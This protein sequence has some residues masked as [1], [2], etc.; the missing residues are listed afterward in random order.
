MR[1]PA[2]LRGR[3]IATACLAVCLAIA[4]AGAAVW[5]LLDRLV[6]GQVDAQLDAQI[7]TVAAALERSPRGEWRLVRPVEGPPFDRRGRGWYWEVRSGDDTPLRSASLGDG[8]VDVEDG[9]E[10]GPRDRPRPAES[11]GPRGEAL[12]ARLRRVGPG[13]PVVVATAPVEAIHG[14]LR[15]ALATVSL[16]LLAVAAA[17]VA[18]ILVQVGLGLRPLRRLEGALADVRAGRRDRVPAD[19]PT[20]LRALAGEL[21]ALLRENAETLAR[22][23]MH[24][25]NLA[26]GLKTPLATLS[27]ALAEPGR[28]PDGRLGREIDGMDRRVRHHLRRAR[29]AALA[30]PVRT[31]TPL[32]PPVA[33][34]ADA[35]RRLFAGKGIAVETAVPDGLA[36]LVERE[37]LDEMLGNLVENACR[38]CRT[39]V[40]VGAES[41]GREV[42]IRVDDDGPGLDP[43]ARE[44][45]LRPGLRLDESQPGSGF[46][47]PITREL[48]DLYGGSLALGAAPAGGLRVVLALPAAAADQ[49]WK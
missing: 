3:L 11:T 9:R 32:G 24:V 37:D 30:G 28:D 29:A 44:A 25:A 4:V 22:A 16:T 38:W 45:V 15:T 10:G 1:W 34:L 49:N 19:Q 46:G 8:H 21:N 41:D 2:S 7:A 23:R 27:L 17:L 43:A 42:V 48:A 14:P 13:G 20:E 40:S 31:R 47:L 18:A 26:H 36:L 5:V 6:R 33:D 35:V 12:W 39:R